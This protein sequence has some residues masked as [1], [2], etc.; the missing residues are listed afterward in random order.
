M[1]VLLIGMI[2]L[3]PDQ[4]SARLN[5]VAQVITGQTDVREEVSIRGRVS[6]LLVAGQ[7]FFDHPILGVG[8]GNYPVYYQSYSRRIGLDPRTENREP[9]NLFLEVA[10]ETGLVGLLVFFTVLFFSVQGIRQAWL[11]FKRL[12]L[13]TYANLVAVFA[14]GVLGY[15]TAALFI[16]GAYPRYMW[17]LIGLALALPQVAR[18]AINEVKKEQSG[19]S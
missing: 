16:H 5:T 14:I 6:E 1:A 3:F 18:N 19:S 12:K 4:Y 17:L 9:H 8:V 7:M 2:A 13:E 10:A 15:F 11:T